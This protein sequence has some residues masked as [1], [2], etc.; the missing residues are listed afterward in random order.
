MRMRPSDSDSNNR[1]E[2][3]ANQEK[4]LSQGALILS[5]E[6]VRSR[7]IIRRYLR[8][9]SLFS[10]RYI[11]IFSWHSQKISNIIDCNNL[12]DTSSVK[13]TNNA[14]KSIT[15]NDRIVLSARWIPISWS[16]RYV[17]S[18]VKSLLRQTRLHRRYECLPYFRWLLDAPGRYPS[19]FSRAE[20]PHCRKSID[21][22]LFSFFFNECTSAVFAGAAFDPFRK[23][24][25]LTA[26][27]I[28]SALGHGMEIREFVRA[29]MCIYIYIYIYIYMYMYMYIYVYICIHMYITAREDAHRGM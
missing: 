15:L 12:S 5:P 23:L 20:S 2:K 21:S 18:W 9:P 11:F 8:F 7:G 26:R 13:K 29:C 4:W 27:S 1:A 17:R 25:S 28:P 3:C 16:L 19:T 24:E 22:F 6:A 14:I 10:A